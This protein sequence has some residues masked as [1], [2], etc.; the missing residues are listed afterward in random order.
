MLTWT[1]MVN[2]YVYTVNR[3]CI[4]NTMSVEVV[5]CLLEH[6]NLNLLCC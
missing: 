3:L 1:L 2:M 6:K 4:T 5:R